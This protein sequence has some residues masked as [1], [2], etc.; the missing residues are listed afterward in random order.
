MGLGSALFVV[1]RSFMNEPCHMRFFM[2]NTLYS[3]G[4]SHTY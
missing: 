4:F 3:D 2:L 1:D